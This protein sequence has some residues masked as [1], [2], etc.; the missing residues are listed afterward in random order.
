ML[1]SDKPYVCSVSHQEEPDINSKSV[2]CTNCDYKSDDF[3]SIKSRTAFLYM[4][5]L[6]EEKRQISDMY[7]NTISG[8]DM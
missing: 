4:G 6:T 7:S 2:M 3:E 1:P 8:P 5:Q